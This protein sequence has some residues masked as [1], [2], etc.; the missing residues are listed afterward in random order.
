MDMFASVARD[1]SPNASTVYLSDP[2]TLCSLTWEM[3]PAVL[4]LGLL[5]LNTVPAEF[6]VSAPAGR[7]ARNI[8][9]WLLLRSQDTDD[10]WMGEVAPRASTRPCERKRSS[11]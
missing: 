2:W 6:A 1:K 5:Y 8:S 10:V 4:A 3:P 7:P 11:P 9:P